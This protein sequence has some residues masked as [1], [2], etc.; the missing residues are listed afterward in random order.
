MVGICDG[1]G[2]D[3]RVVQRVLSERLKRRIGARPEDEDAA[4]VGDWLGRICQAMG[5]NLLREDAVSREKEVGRF[6]RDY[7]G[8]ECDRGSVLGDQIDAGGVGEGFCKR[9]Q[10]G[11][12]V[13]CGGDM[14]LM[15]DGLGVCR[16]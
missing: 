7:P 5:D 13:G 16:W 12:E 9:G 8:C 2:L 6:A 3:S 15:R 4:C 14:Y 1:E 11:L 10:D